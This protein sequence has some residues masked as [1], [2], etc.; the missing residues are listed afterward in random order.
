ML[1][2]IKQ[3]SPS[4]AGLGEE[5]DPASL[6]P[7]H[8]LVFSPGTRALVPMLFLDK[9]RDRDFRRMEDG[10]GSSSGCLGFLDIGTREEE[11]GM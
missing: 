11:A 8:Q 5:E 2:S 10:G 3:T 7:P 9:A 4:A 6:R 1:V